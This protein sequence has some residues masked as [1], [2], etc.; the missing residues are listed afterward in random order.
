[1]SFEYG[2]RYEVDTVPDY[3]D[4]RGSGRIAIQNMT[5]VIRFSVVSHDGRAQFVVDQTSVELENYIAEF[6]GT[7]ELAEGL[8][9]FLDAFKPIFKKEI[10]SMATRKISKMLQ[11]NINTV[12]FN[13]PTLIPVINDPPTSLNY[14]MIS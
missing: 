2:L 11:H 3:F 8:N 12:I 13:Q 7:H 5:L 10:L 1:M 6:K 9:M 4:D 14:T